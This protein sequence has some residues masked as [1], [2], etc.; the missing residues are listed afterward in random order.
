MIPKGLVQKILQKFY[1]EKHLKEFQR[2]CKEFFNSR[3]VEACTECLSEQP[4][5]EGWF[6]EWLLFDFQLNNGQSILENFVARHGNSI[7]KNE[8]EDVNALINSFFGLFE[9]L[10]ID[11]NKGLRL[12]SLQTGEEYEVK[13][14][15]ATHQLA[16][17]H[18]MFA[19]IV[20]MGDQCE[21]AN[22]N[23]ISIPMKLGNRLRKSFLNSSEVLSPKYVYEL[24]YGGDRNKNI[25]TKEEGY[26]KGFLDKDEDLNLD[27]SIADKELNA[28]LKKMDILD[29]VDASLVRKWIDYDTDDEFDMSYLTMLAGLFQ[30]GLDE[31]DAEEFSRVVQNVHSTTPQKR[32]GGKTPQQKVLE[33]PHREPDI[34][35]DQVPLPPLEW[36]EHYTK[37]FQNFSKADYAQ[38]VEEYNRCF[39]LLQKDKTTAP[40]PYRLFANKALAHFS[41]GERDMGEVMLKMA[42]EMNPN[43]DFGI[44]VRERLES[45]EY[46]DLILHG[47]MTTLKK[48]KKVGLTFTI[49][50]KKLEEQ[51]QQ[52]PAW[53]YYQFLKRYEINFSTETRTETPLRFLRYDGKKMRRND[54]CLCGAKNEDGKAVKYKKCCG[55]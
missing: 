3:D 13:E 54:P 5:V 24:M 26:L 44:Q 37:A 1:S 2:A 50:E 33:D 32:I 34:I 49:D 4:D 23:T 21:L 42:L 17:G 9:V 43:Y 36:N 27:P 15:S 39:E 22:A 40:E 6:N 35:F 18:L 53:Q 48:A 20:Q 28:F 55:K 46:D 45:G 8:L 14:R 11:R 12:K 10:R 25:E 47:L 31:V 7:S 30:D 52:D 16:Q 38:A 41:I 29:K 19:R 51:L